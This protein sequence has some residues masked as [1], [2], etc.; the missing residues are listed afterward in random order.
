M[1]GLPILAIAIF[2]AAAAEDIR[3]RRIPNPL[4]GALLVL[5]LIRLLGAGTD[6][7]PAPAADL[8]AALLIFAAGAMLFQ[9][10]ALGGGDV[11]LLAAG[12]LWVGAGAAAS[13][14]MITA[15]AGGALALA[16]ILRRA[17]GHDKPPA[18]ASL[19]YGVAIAMGGIFAGPPLY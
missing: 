3:H 15:L 6:P 7:G 4:V 10:G 11:K 18:H 16:F 9:F 19:P 12:M 17:L 13:Y 1:Q 5:G 2:L 8:V 14:L